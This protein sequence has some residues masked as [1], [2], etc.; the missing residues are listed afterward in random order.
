[1][2]ISS[3]QSPWW[4]QHIAWWRTDVTR[5]AANSH[6]SLWSHAKVSHSSLSSCGMRLWR[7][8]LQLW[9]YLDSMWSCCR[10]W[11]RLIKL[12]NYNIESFNIPFIGHLF[13]QSCISVVAWQHK[14]EWFES[15]L[16]EKLLIL[17][18]SCSSWGQLGHS[19]VGHTWAQL[20]SFRQRVGQP[21]AGWSWTASSTCLVVSWSTV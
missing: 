13:H 3:T 15:A 6:S 21:E 14:V 20:G 10:H 19:S 16:I 4:W 12:Q 17:A 9:V 18:I 1:M 8:G 5:R 11:N 2:C 7:C